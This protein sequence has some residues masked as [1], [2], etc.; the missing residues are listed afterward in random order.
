MTSVRIAI[1]GMHCASCSALIEKMVGRMPGVSE[2]TVNLAANNGRVAFDPAQ[3]SVEAILKK[4]DDL[5]FHAVV[6]PEEHR[7]DFDRARRAEAARA[8]RHNLV[9][10]AVAVVLTVVILIIGM[11][12]LGHTWSHM[13]AVAL[14]LGGE[15]GPMHT[16]VMLVMNLILLVLCIPVQFWCGARFFKGA[17]GSLKN[18]AGSMDTLV[19]VGTGCAF[20]YSL[21]VTFAPSMA[22]TMAPYETSA[23]LITFVMIGKTLESRA[24][25]RAGDAIEQLMDLSPSTAHVLRNGVEVDVPTEQ[26]V[27]GDTLVVRAGERIPVDGVVV[28]G[29][30]DVDESMITGEP[31]PQ[32]KEAGSNV[33]GGTLNRLG[34][35]KVRALKVG[36][37]TTLSQIVRLVEEAQGSHPPVQRLADRIA[38]VFVP[39]VLAV[40]VLA[41]L[42]WFF[43]LPALGV[44]APYG[45]HSVF[46][47]ALLVAVS[48]VVVACPCALGLA[49]PTA[50]MVGT[51]R[52][53]ELGILVKDGAVLETSGK[54][55][56]VVFDKTGT[57]TQ[58]RPSVVAVAAEDG[59]NGEE[60]VRLAGA[61]EQGSAHPLAQ[62]VTA[63]AGEDEAAR[64][65]AGEELAGLPPVEG[66][67]ELVGLGVVGTVE[68]EFLAVGNERLAAL[69]LAGSDL[70]EGAAEAARGLPA[71][72]CGAQVRALLDGGDTCVLVV[73]TTRG[74][75]GAL[76][77]AD[78]V[79][80]S[81]AAGVAALAERGVRVWMLTG[82]AEQA[83]GRVAAEVGV[84]A[85]RVMARVLPGDKA[86]RVSELR[87]DGRVVAMVGDGINDTPALAA[88]DLGIAMGS[89]SDAALEAGSVVLMNGDVRLVARTVDLS[90]A[91]MRK[92]HQN[93]A[94]AL[95]YNVLMIPLAFCGILVPEVSSACMALS[96]VSVVTSSLLLGR[97][98]KN[99][100]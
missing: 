59:V 20:L 83:A 98:G 35:L 8:R 22:G 69:V 95:G 4:V 85:E 27:A 45:E 80:D 93:F 65:E 28:E 44:T 43:L 15:V 67:R 57:L 87:A 79:K 76:A 58:G 63:R 13:L 26:V 68:G 16:Q 14:G 71:V 17:W 50:V 47:K 55:T 29:S 96:S 73:S 30:S 94:W 31:M 77:I 75:L 64:V 39:C 2:C 21:Y 89:G 18:G 56:D 6:I 74:V 24:K 78:Q 60:L 19:A 62:A 52:G 61:V 34:A 46:E 42:V 23:M 11:T 48:V 92:I 10:L 54:V 1:E 41:F 86:A 3:A 33:V 72:V 99:G 100:R 91:T 51:G 5:G 37:D 88:S 9:Q 81:A 36:G 32:S 25:G 66:F 90:R 40:A 84:P 49:T 7:G 82:D 12:P 53:A 70:G 97:F 38:A